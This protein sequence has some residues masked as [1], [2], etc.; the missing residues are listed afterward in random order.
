[1]SEIARLPQTAGPDQRSSRLTSPDRAGQPSEP[2]VSRAFEL[3]PVP[4]WVHDAETGRF[5]AVNDCAVRHYGYG[6]EQFLAMTVGDLSQPD[7]ERP[8]IA[9]GATRAEPG[10]ARTVRQRKA[11]GTPVAARLEMSSMEVDGRPATLVIAIDVTEDDRMLRDLTASE[12]ALRRAEARYRQLF[13]TA[14]DW[15][16]EQDTKGCL[17]LVSANFEAMYGVSIAD[18]IGK[19][20]NHMA[21][22]TF[23]VESGR[24]SLAAIKA[25]QPFRDL[26][27]SRS[28]ADGRTI[29]VRTSGIPMFDGSGQ[30][31]GY[32][33]VS[34]DVTAQLESERAL[35][36]SEQ[37]T[38]RVLEA[39]ADAYWEQD[40]G[41]RYTYLSPSWE[42]RLGFVAAECIGKRQTEIS[43]MSPGIDAA[44]MV[45]A[46]IKAKQPYR[47]FVF[48]HVFADGS[49]RWFKAS[50]AP[51]F[52]QGGKFKGYRG[53]AAEITQQVEAE[54]VAR[55]AQE[56]LHEAV[57]HVTQPISVY[58]EKDRLRACNQAFVDLHMRISRL[59]GPVT[60][61]KLRWQTGAAYRELAEW[62]VSSGFY[63]G[64][65]DDPRIDVETLLARYRSEEEH[66]YHLCDG[67]WMQAVYH[68]LPDGGRVGLWT[69]VTALK[70]AEKEKRALETQLQH[71]QRLEALGTL[72]GGAAHEINNALVPVIALTK[73]V[74]GKLA[75]DSRER[76]NLG[77]VVTGAE[78]ARDLLKQILAFSRKAERRRESFD[79]AVVVQEALSMMRAT[80]PATIRI[81][82]RIAPVPTLAGDPNQLHQIVVNIV[83]NAV[84]A[85]GDGMGTI[86][87]ALAPDADGAHLRLSVTDTGCGMDE[88]TK[89]R[90]F[91]PFFT[92]KDVGKGTGLGLGVVH[93]IVEDHGGRIEVE[94]A[95]GRGT[96]FDIVLPLVPAAASDAA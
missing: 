47:D 5:L 91:E 63:A 92:T 23:D 34:K 95:P 4:M 90:I 48:A 69:D 10:A 41:Y 15:Y 75:E 52:D 87:V 80:A 25:R 79:L 30:F 58:D 36:E 73:L 85:I 39:A 53:I 12:S 16:W 42:D 94:S 77:L 3:S 49:K 54:A 66:T 44:A 35:R 27:Y 56:D 18:M 40:E 50:G 70:T 9:A 38:R 55:L 51:I 24:R 2:A 86:S 8:D 31:C 81:E 19:R 71:A 64:G 78:R 93:G 20:A 89:A 67:R 29:Q 1:M 61:A 57:A 37:E 65:P 68:R 7:G 21:D 46:A 32:C 17:T 59:V 11:D 83:T 96:R 62:Q 82:E 22:A 84:H 72:S 26:L 88:A 76:R 74:A 13:E 6:R 33:G 28:L 14:S 43:G 60:Q 45:L